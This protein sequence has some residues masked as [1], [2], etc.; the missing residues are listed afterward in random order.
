MCLR[1]QSAVKV[2]AKPTTIILKG[3]GKI[4]T[5][6]KTRKILNVWLA[7]LLFCGNEN[8]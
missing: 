3:Y 4:Y 7:C 8:Q 2:D 1:E 5:C 6:R